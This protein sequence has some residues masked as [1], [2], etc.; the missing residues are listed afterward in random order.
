MI[1]PINPDELANW[2]LPAA[3]GRDFTNWWQGGG[4]TFASAALG[5]LATKYGPAAVS[6]LGAASSFGS[7]AVPFLS[8]L[9]I[10]GNPNMTAED[11]NKM[12]EEANE[13]MA[14]LEAAGYGRIFDF[15]LPPPPGIPPDSFLCCPDIGEITDDFN[16]LMSCLDQLL[17]KLRGGG[18]STGVPDLDRYFIQQDLLNCLSKCL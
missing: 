6:W 5:G 17:S 13:K 7:R 2:R 18:Y 8:L 1:N 4:G 11:Y 15:I 3:V 10:S 16:C 12:I 14:E 9:C